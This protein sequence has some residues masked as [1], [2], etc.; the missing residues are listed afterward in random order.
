MLYALIPITLI[1]GYI[2]GYLITKRKYKTEI[3]DIYSKLRK[4]TKWME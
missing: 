4:G 1:I 3:N 2:I